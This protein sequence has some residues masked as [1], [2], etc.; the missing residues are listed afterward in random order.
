MTERSAVS[1]RPADASDL[2]SIRAIS[3][4][5]HDPPDP[6][7]RS[8]PEAID[9][10]YLHLIEHGTVL[11]AEAD[12]GPVGFGATV[13]SGRGVHLADLFVVPERQGRGIGRRLLEDAFGDSWPRTTFSSDD[14]R[15]LPLYVRMGMRPL[16]PNL[17][18]AGDGRRLPEPAGLEVLAATPEDV[19]ALEREWLGIERPLQHRYWAS[20]PEAVPMVVR[21]LRRAVAAGHARSRLVGGGRWFS[22]FTVA[23][24]EEPV[25]PTLAALRWSVD[26][27]GRIGTCVLGPH[28]V[29]P[30]LIASG[31]R[32]TDRDTYQASDPRLLDPE[33]VLVNTGF[34]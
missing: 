31:F 33:R 34:L 10:Y 25:G 8:F 14:P 20:Q 15:A 23:P 11:M 26:A 29:V 3:A 5:G 19:A 16:H 1:I 17:Y 24:G 32:V 7:T 2:A 6:A 22:N 21:R 27:D 28:P 4:A 13:G 12:D 9:A 30:E 18:L